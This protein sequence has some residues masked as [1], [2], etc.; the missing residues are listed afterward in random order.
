MKTLQIAF[1]ELLFWMQMCRGHFLLCHQCQPTPT[2]CRHFILL[3]VSNTYPPFLCVTFPWTYFSSSRFAFVSDLSRLRPPVTVITR[4][5]VLC[6][7]VP[8]HASVRRHPLGAPSNMFLQCVNAFWVPRV[9][10][11]MCVCCKR[12]DSCSVLVHFQTSDRLFHFPPRA[13]FF[14]FHFSHTDPQPPASLRW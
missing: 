13:S 9:C 10:K 2:R 7:N 4:R 11:C 5:V 12:A 3:S 14:S 6:I 8:Q 1:A